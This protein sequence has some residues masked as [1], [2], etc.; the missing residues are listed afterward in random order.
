MPVSGAVPGACHIG[1]DGAR[2]SFYSNKIVF[3]KNF[4]LIAMLFLL[5]SLVVSCAKQDEPSG[6]PD[7]ADGSVSAGLVKAIILKDEATGSSVT[8][9]LYAQDLEYLTSDD[10]YFKP[11]FDVDTDAVQAQSLPAQE[12]RE[13]DTS[14][15]EVFLT[16]YVLPAGAKGFHFQ[17][18]GNTLS[19]GRSPENFDI[20]GRFGVCGA[21]GSRIRGV[22]V[23]NVPN[24]NHMHYYLRKKT[25]TDNLFWQ[26]VYEGYSQNSNAFIGWFDATVDYPVWRFRIDPDNNC[27]DFP[28]FGFLASGC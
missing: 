1:R 7:L 5:A 15:T 26:Q 19:R 21:G 8:V 13:E 2:L 25:S 9:E 6:V 17:Y 10:F 11:I 3:M 12:G 27:N 24:C 28:A 22:T 16:D 18:L 14:P 4:F 23:P 20:N